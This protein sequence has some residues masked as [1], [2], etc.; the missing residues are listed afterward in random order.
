[1]F[2]NV[3][4]IE[5]KLQVRSANGALNREYSGNRNRDPNLREMDLEVIIKCRW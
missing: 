3:L 2:A 1:M 5:S 4:V